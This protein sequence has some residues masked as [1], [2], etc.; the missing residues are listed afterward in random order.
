MIS[1]ELIPT[2]D[3]KNIVFHALVSSS[4]DEKSCNFNKLISYFLN[5]F[6]GKWI[7]HHRSSTYQTLTFKPKDESVEVCFI[8]QSI[9]N[10]NIVINFFVRKNNTMKIVPVFVGKSCSW[11]SNCAVVPSWEIQSILGLV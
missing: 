9:D 6:E 4:R 3:L 10:D 11:Y 5:S 2:K 1:I 8:F 7:R